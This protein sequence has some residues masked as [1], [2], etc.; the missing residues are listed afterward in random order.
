[1]LRQSR[2]VWAS[3]TSAFARSLTKYHPPTSNVKAR[4]DDVVPGVIGAIH[5]SLF[6]PQGAT[7]K[8]HA[9]QH[10]ALPEGFLHRPDDRASLTMGNALLFP[11]CGG[12]QDEALSRGHHTA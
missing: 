1:M 2:P 7:G 11:G 6:Q 3:F 12:V 8:V 9:Y 5:G 4:A 10:H